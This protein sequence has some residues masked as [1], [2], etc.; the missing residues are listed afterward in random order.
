MSIPMA[1]VSPQAVLMPGTILRGKTVVGPGCVIGPNT[2]AE[3]AVFGA[4]TVVNSSQVFQ[5]T[6]GQNCHV[7]PY[8]YVRAGTQTGDNAKIGDFVE[9]RNTKIGDGAKLAHLSY[10]ADT[11][12]GRKRPVRLRRGD[13]QL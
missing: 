9:V 3:D 13:G 2:Y 12:V 6:L 5:A 11:E 1:Q 4:G 7:G 10:V 8:A